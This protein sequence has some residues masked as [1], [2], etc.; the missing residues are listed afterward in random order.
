MRLRRL[1]LAGAIIPAMIFPL[2]GTAS[3]SECVYDVGVHNSVLL[4]GRRVHT[5]VGVCID[6]CPIGSVAFHLED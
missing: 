6:A 4:F 2:A 3:A 1:L 5:C